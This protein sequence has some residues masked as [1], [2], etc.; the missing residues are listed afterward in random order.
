MFFL[1]T[2][3]IDKI[4]IEINF[5]NQYGEIKWNIYWLQIDAQQNSFH[6]LFL[7]KLF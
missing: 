5:E 1:R 3:K 2:N 6:K 7:L 4:T